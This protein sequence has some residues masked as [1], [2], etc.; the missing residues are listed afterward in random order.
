M[1]DKIFIKVRKLIADH[2]RVDEARITMETAFK[3][4][5][6]ADSLDLVELIM[7]LEETFDLEIEETAAENIKTVGDAVGYIQKHSK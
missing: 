4:D 7:G 5:L 1:S 3:E 2:L 6:R